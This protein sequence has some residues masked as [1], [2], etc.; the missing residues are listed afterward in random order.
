VVAVGV[1][2][3]VGCGAAVVSRLMPLIL[4]MVCADY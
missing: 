2:H 3:G 1:V 4:M